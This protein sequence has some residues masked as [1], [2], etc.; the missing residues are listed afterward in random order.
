MGLFLRVREERERLGFSQEAFA[1]LGGASRK[2]QIRWEQ[3]EGGSP[4]AEVL[5]AWAAAGADIQY[6]VT[7]TRSGSALGADEEVLLDAYRVLEPSMRRRVLAFILG[8]EPAPAA[9]KKAK[10]TVKSG[11]GQQFNGPVGVV[12]EGDI[13]AKGKEKKS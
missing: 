1:A 4:D 9:P 12:A 11:V 13:H 6:I 5:R 3:A 7:G 8:G 10:Q 2:S